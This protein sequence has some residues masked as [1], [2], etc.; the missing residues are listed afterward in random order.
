MQRVND[1]AGFVYFNHAIHVAKGVACVTCHGPIGDM[2][3]T[4]AAH[5]MQMRW[6]LGC[7]RDPAPNLVPPAE[8][9][10]P[11]ADP[12]SEVADLHAIL[13]AKGHIDPAQ[14]TDCYVCHR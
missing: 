6:C 13:L 5:P 9:F 11:R 2:P 3:L 14:I 12:S 8:V 1:L 4:R 10:N 7:H